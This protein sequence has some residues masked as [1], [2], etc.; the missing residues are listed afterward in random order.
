MKFAMSDEAANQFQL[1]FLG[2][3]LYGFHGPLLIVVGVGV[4]AAGVSLG[5]RFSSTK[6]ASTLIPA[7]F[8]ILMLW[9]RADYSK[10]LLFD[11]AAADVATVASVVETGGGCTPRRS[12]VTLS[13]GQLVGL[14]GSSLLEA[15]DA[16]SLKST[17]LGKFL[18]AG[19][20]RTTDCAKIE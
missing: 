3:A 20:G 2:E 7:V 17:R 14:R 13:D 18:C 11:T 16:A 1:A 6:A 19:D 8:F 5:I 12:H 15:G 9:S 10:A 4:F